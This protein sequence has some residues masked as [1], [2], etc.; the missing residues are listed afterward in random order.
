MKL[1][2]V[3]AVKPVIAKLSN[4]ELPIT[5]SYKLCKSL[6]VLNDE[7]DVVEKLR[8]DLVRRY[9]ETKENGS[10]EVTKDNIPKFVGEFK[11]LLDNDINIKLGG[12]I[13]ISDIIDTG[14][15]VTPA[16][17]TILMKTG[18]LE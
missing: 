7:A 15:K 12:A 17:L 10:F 16:E 1:N 4:L 3:L 11:A 6:K 13:K 14:I 2:D 5:V 8:L 18:I 9:G